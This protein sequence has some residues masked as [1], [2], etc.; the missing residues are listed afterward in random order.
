[1]PPRVRRKPDEAKRL[2]LDAASKL[3]A[4]GGPA[5]VQVRAVAVEIGVSD[6]AINHHFGT[7]DQLLEA[8]LRFGGASLRNGLHAVLDRWNDCPV[9]LADLVRAL[10]RLYADGF[11]ELALALHR[12][13]WRDTSTGMLDEVVDRLFDDA[14]QQCAATG[15]RAPTREEIR[16]TVAALHQAMATQPLFGNE[17]RRSAGLDAATPEPMIEWWIRILQTTL[18]GVPPAA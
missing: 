10:H 14:Q 7:R 12:S 9:D 3:L 5:A 18:A 13:G 8:L 11:A 6:A 4:A 15:H 16:L 1:M 17:F 2:I